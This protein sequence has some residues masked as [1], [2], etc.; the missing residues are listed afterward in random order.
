MMKYIL[1]LTLKRKENFLQCI[2]THSGSQVVGLLGTP[3]ST[4]EFALPPFPPP[5]TPGRGGILRLL[6]LKLN[7]NPNNIHTIQPFSIQLLNI[8]I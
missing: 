3:Y 8:S 1:I 2:P 6:H 4:F 5:P 7:F